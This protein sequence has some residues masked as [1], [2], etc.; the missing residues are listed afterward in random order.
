MQ[1]HE[2]LAYWKGLFETNYLTRNPKRK[3]EWNYGLGFVSLRAYFGRDVKKE[4]I[5]SVG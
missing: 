2:D 1:L 3:L 5:C 4:F